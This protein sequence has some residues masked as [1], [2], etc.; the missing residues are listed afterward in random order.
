[1]AR[2]NDVA[3]IERRK[4]AFVMSNYARIIESHRTEAPASKMKVIFWVAHTKEFNAD[5]TSGKTKAQLKSMWESMKQTA[6]KDVAAY[7]RASKKTG[8]GPG[9]WSDSTS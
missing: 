5:G 4:L 7:R 6:K 2:R 1:M 9:P 8:G 3:I